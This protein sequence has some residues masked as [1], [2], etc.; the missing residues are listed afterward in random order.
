MHIQGQEYNELLDGL[1]KAVHP[2]W[3]VWIL[4]KLK[5]Q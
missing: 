4:L 5:V 2:D 3:T 1:S